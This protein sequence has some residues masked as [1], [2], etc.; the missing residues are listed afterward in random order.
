MLHGWYENP[1]V[2]RR[3]PHIITVELL[4]LVDKSFNNSI[5]GGNS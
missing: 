2:K 4:R 5:I 3:I 1:I